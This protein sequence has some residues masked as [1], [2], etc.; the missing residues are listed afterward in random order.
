MESSNAIDNSLLQPFLIFRS[1]ERT[2]GFPLAQ[3]IETMRVLPVEVVPGMQPFLNGLAMIR[4][5]L[6]PVV[7]L[8]QLL[9][10]ATAAAT[11]LP[12]RY[13]TVRLGQRV[14][15][16]AVSSVVGVRQLAADT[17][18]TL[19]TL[20]ALIKVTDNALLAAIGT[21]DADLFLVLEAARVIPEALWLELDAREM[22]A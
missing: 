3:V 2:C 19:P 15:A 5:A 8:A 20:P 7:N 10:A 22:C 21:L 13:V 11:A 14:V 12:T 6:V 1:G 9:D 17:L 18:D 16:F 4:G